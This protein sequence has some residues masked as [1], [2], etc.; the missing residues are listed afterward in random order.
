MTTFSDNKLPLPSQPWGREVTKAITSLESKVESERINN[1]ARDNQLNSSIIAN[2][3]A[4]IRAQQAADDV[5]AVVNNIYSPGTTELDG[6]K[7]KSGTLSASKITTGTLDA[8]VVAVT[9]LNASNITTGSLSA[10]RITTGTL[11]ASNVTVTNLSANSITTGSLSG[12]RITGGTITGTVIQTATS[13]QRAVI[14]STQISFYSPSSGGGAIYGNS[15]GGVSI[16]NSSGSYVVRANPSSAALAGGGAA[17]A[18]SADRVDL[19]ASLTYVSGSL[20][21]GAT[22]IGGQLTLGSSSAF[23][24][25]A[26]YTPAGGT[27]AAA[28]NM[29]VGSNGNVVRTTNTSSR[30]SKRDIRELE[31]NSDN[32]LS[33]KPVIFKYNEGILR[34][35]EKDW[36]IIGFIAEDFED[37]GFADELIVQPDNPNEMVELKYNKMYMFLHKIVSGQNQTIKDLTARIEALESKV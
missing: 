14:G 31:F 13:G 16:Q 20:N 4:T 32:Y 8:S 24:A 11:N 37:A 6:A 9:N 35:E 27:S 30:K 2:Q 36:D 33:V 26:I 18:V 28:T 12:D 21:A 29:Y 10:D 1:T 17:V 22:T 15:D 5:T 3:A 7:V 25:P 19:T 34:E 23:V